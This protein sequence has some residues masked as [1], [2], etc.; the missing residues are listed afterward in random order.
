MA[1]LA[2]ALERSE[3][4]QETLIQE[5]VTV[6]INTKKPEYSNIPGGFVIVLHLQ[7]KDFSCC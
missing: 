4:F 6:N 2:A 1:L 3:S 5:N 7:C